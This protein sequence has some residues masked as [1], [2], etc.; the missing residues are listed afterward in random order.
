M[1]GGNVSSVYLE[2]S[3]LLNNKLGKVLE[4]YDPSRCQELYSDD[5]GYALSVKSDAV[6]VGKGSQI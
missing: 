1:S 5:S 2:L 3:S 6:S 4:D